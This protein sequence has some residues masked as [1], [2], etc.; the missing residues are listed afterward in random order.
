MRRFLSLLR[1]E[2]KHP[3]IRS[4]SLRPP[5]EQGGIQA[6]A[7]A[8]GHTDDVVAIAQ[9]PFGDEPFEHQQHRWGRAVAMGGEYGS[10]G[11]QVS[12]VES[13]PLA[14]PVHYAWPSRMNRPCGNVLGP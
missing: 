4:P 5:S 7:G 8:E 1:S 9:G 11:S 3:V 10:G 2:P 6:E 14:N 12:V 13:Q